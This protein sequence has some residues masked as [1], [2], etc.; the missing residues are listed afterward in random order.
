MLD[1][2][3]MSKNTINFLIE[4]NEKIIKGFRNKAFPYKYMGVAITE[5]NSL[6]DGYIL[7]NYYDNRKEIKKIF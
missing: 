5:D 7:L 3:K 2:I 4:Q 6:S 1:A